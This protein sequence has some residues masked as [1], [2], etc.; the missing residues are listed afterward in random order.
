VKRTGDHNFKA[1]GNNMTTEIPMDLAPFVQRMISERRYLN[2]GDVVAEG[3]RML[4]A[5]ESLREEVAKGF[6]Q[7][8]AGQGIPAEQFYSRAEARISQIERG[9]A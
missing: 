1:L 5:R 3:L 7:L 6:A 9:E 4:Q 2:E 8:D